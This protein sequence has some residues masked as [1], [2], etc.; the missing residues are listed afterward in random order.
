MK[1]LIDTNVVLDMLLGRKPFVEAADPIF[2]LAARNVFEAFVT[3]NM[4]TDIYYVLRKSLSAP[5]TKA[6]MA[7]L[8]DFFEI[9]PVSALECQLALASP[10]PDF[11]DA[12]LEACARRAGVERIIS[13]DGEFLAACPLAI[14]PNAFL[15]EIQGT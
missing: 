13:R 5:R 12:L 11:E 8:L 9:I 1:V 14:A 10:N 3:A 2:S 4:L 15:G 7:Y 6:Q